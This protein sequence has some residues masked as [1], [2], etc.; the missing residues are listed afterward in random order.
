MLY[1]QVGKAF[2]GSFGKNKEFIING[3]LQ[4]AQDIKHGDIRKWTTDVKQ[5][6]KK[7]KNYN[8]NDWC[9]GKLAKYNFT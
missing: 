6:L 7:P 8:Y 9:E 5:L 3:Y 4:D 2:Q 1:Y